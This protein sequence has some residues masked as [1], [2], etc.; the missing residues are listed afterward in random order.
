VVWKIGVDEAGRGALAGPV[1]AG[2]VLL[3]DSF[4]RTLLKDSKQLSAASRSFIY[5]TLKNSSAIIGVGIVNQK[6]IDQWNILQST[7]VAMRRAVEQVVYRVHQVSSGQALEAWIDGNRLPKGLPI[8]AFTLVKGDQLDPAISAASIVA[9]VTRDQLMERA[10]AC[11]PQ[12]GFS[13][14]QGYAT[15]S[16][17]EA[18]YT[19][20]VLP[21]HRQSF[22]LQQQG[23]LF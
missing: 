12:Y 6:R 5:Q 8:P 7:M 22:Q 10:H 18:I 16:H 14:H 13:D 9:K 3:P 4:D 23:R 21:I 15:Q 17:Y 1:V 20:G 2:A 11:Y 19:Y